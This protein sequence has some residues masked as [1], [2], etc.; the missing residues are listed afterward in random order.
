MT[1]FDPTSKHPGS[2]LPL[3]KAGL[4]PG[5]HDVFTTEVRTH[6][7]STAASAGGHS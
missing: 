7:F 4:V 5:L 2:R 6:P 1:S 3:G